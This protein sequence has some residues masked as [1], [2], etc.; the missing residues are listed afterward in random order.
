[1]IKFVLAY[2]LI[3]LAFTLLVMFAEWFGKVKIGLSNEYTRK[4]Y[5]DLVTKMSLLIMWPYVAY[6]LICMIITIHK[7]S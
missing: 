2:L 1:M 7:G 6:L 4:N 3:G 5:S